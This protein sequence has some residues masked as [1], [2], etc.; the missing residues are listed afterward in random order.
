MPVG[1]LIVWLV[2]ALVVAD[3]FV[4]STTGKDTGQAVLN[5][6]AW[7]QSSVMVLVVFSRGITPTAIVMS[8]ST[9]PL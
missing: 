7:A 5:P 8:G 4:A 9:V 3:S 2:P 1:R 6:T